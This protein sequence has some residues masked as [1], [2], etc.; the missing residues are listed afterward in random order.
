MRSTLFCS[1]MPSTSRSGVWCTL[2]DLPGLRRVGRVCAAGR[3]RRGR[4]SAASTF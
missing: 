1:W 2:R 4:T 3:I